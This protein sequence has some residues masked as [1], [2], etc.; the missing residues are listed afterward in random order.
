[1]KIILPTLTKLKT[2]KKTEEVKKGGKVYKTEKTYCR[3]TN[4]LDVNK[5]LRA[6][7]GHVDASEPD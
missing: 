2:D 4:R 5:R 3:I 7:F 6:D 1:M